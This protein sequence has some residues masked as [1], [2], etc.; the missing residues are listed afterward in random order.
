MRGPLSLSRIIAH[1]GAGEF[2]IMKCQNL[3][4]QQDE[5]ICAPRAKVFA[6]IPG[7]KLNFQSVSRI[8]QGTWREGGGGGSNFLAAAQSTPERINLP[9]R[10]V[11]YRVKIQAKRRGECIYQGQSLRAALNWL[12]R[13]GDAS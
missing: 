12:S 2:A 7:A 8:R 9:G 3:N 10:C 11:A 4:P 6:E 1:G 5:E 13:L